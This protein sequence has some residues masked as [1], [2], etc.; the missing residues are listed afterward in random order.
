MSGGC[1]VARPTCQHQA[2]FCRPA[3]HTGH[4]GP[5]APVHPGAAQRGDCGPGVRAGR[6]W[7]RAV[8]PSL[9]EI[10][11]VMTPN[12]RLFVWISMRVER[13]WWLRRPCP[14][15]VWILAKGR[16]AVVK[17]LHSARFDTAMV[18]LRRAYAVGHWLMKVGLSTAQGAVHADGAALQHG[19]ADRAV[20]PR[21]ATARAAA[22]FQGITKGREHI[23]PVW[24]PGCRT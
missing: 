11:F 3:A 5:G 18:L 10:L 22:A 13:V 16:A 24:I 2:L 7:R 14:T 15:E 1:S 21:Q 8:R 9:Y 17:R 19:D 23:A 12:S 6:R 4:P 20:H